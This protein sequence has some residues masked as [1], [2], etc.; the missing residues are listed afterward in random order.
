MANPTPL[1]H[2]RNYELEN[3]VTFDKTGAGPTIDRLMVIANV[4][5]AQAYPPCRIIIGALGLGSVSL[6]A[7][8]SAELRELLARAEDDVSLSVPEVTPPATAATGAE[9]RCESCSQPIRAGELVHAYEDATVH[10][11]RARPRSPR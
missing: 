6:T 4:S 7:E 10:A 11:G 9:G 2:W 1:T 5:P 8:Q 3:V